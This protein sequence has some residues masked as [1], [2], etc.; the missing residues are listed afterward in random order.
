MLLG[1]LAEHGQL[2][3]HQGV[4]FDFKMFDNEFVAEIKV[5]KK[6][7]ITPYIDFIQYNDDVF[8]ADLKQFETAMNYHERLKEKKYKQWKL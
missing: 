7:Q 8:I 6:F 1:I 4:F 3:K 5:S 2:I